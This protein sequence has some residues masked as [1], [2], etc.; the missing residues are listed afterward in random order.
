V[1]AARYRA[2][3]RRHRTIANGKIPVARPGRHSVEFRLVWEENGNALPG[4]RARR[5]RPGARQPLG[6]SEGAAAGP[7]SM[8]RAA[9]RAAA[10][11]CRTAAVDGGY[12][13]VAVWKSDL[14]GS[15]IDPL[16]GVFGERAANRGWGP[17]FLRNL[18]LRRHHPICP[19]NTSPVTD[20]KRTTKPDQR[21]RQG[22]REIM[23]L[24]AV[25]VTVSQERI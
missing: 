7:P 10:V 1:Q 21:Y 6:R 9:M 12:A 24:M 15:D 3:S 14:V 19:G 23:G 16:H 18:A 8:R 17:W 2:A 11:K 20:P 25:A 4:D 13:M 5:S 22:K